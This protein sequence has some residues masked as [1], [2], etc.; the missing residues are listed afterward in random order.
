[1]MVGGIGYGGAQALSRANS[2]GGNG[3]A[4]G[5]PGI[6]TGTFSGFNSLRVA[7][8]RPPGA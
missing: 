2:G 7:G 8:T 6:M 1:M 5:T 4:L 3:R